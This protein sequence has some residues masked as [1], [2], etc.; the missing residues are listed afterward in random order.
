[1]MAQLLVRLGV[2]DPEDPRI[3]KHRSP[4][5]R[6]WRGDVVGQRRAVPFSD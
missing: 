5:I 3:A 4:P 2:A 6:N 1:V